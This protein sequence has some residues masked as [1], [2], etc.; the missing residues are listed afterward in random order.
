MMTVTRK[1]RFAVVLV[2]AC[3]AAAAGDDLEDWLD[4]NDDVA[5]QSV[6]EGELVFLTGSQTHRVLQTRNWLNITATSLQTGWVGLQQ[7][8]VNLD[9]VAA[10]EVVYRYHGLRNLQVVSTRNVGRAGVEG[11]SVQLED[12]TEGGEVCIRA[13]VQVLRPAATDGYLLQSGPFH[14]RFL[15]GYYPVHLDYRVRWPADLLRLD[16]VRP[17]QQTGFGLRVQQ[18]ELV[19]DTLFEGKLTI[20]VTFGK[21]READ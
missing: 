8:Q 13:E 2:F 7:C 12:V 3:L 19:I 1:S 5:V 4:S 6:N 9:P 10:V 11:N 15:D 21:P 20:E 18:G 17:E 14:R 16:S